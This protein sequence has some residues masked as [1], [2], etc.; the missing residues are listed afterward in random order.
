MMTTLRWLQAVRT[1]LL[2]TALI[3]ISFTT[4]C[5]GQ[6]E[7]LRFGFSEG[8][9]SGRDF[10][11]RQL[12]TGYAAGGRSAVI[13]EAARFGGSIS[14]EIDDRTLLLYFPS[15]EAAF[16]AANA[17]AALPET[18]YVERN[19]IMRIPRPA[20]RGNNKTPQ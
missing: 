5:A 12:I 19:G 1:N 8:L 17:L 13:T 20:E 9:V 3:A 10:V 11:P 15:D 14:S 6:H 7:K 2:F 18:E 16:N 4:A